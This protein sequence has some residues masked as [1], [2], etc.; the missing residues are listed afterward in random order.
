[1]K[2][3][4]GTFSERIGM[5]G[6]VSV[7]LITMACV[8]GMIWL[9]IDGKPPS[10]QLA[11]IAGAGMGIIGAALKTSPD[12]SK[13]TNPGAAAEHVDTL[14]VHTQPAPGEPTPDPAA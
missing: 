5:V 2:T 7:A 12:E 3:I 4:P 1:M 10:A 9:E 11:M 13:K 8:G 14:N 6:M